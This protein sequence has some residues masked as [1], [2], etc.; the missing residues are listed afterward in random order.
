MKSDK[1]VMIVCLVVI[2][3]FVFFL[4]SINES[5]R[6]S[7]AN[8]EVKDEKTPVTYTCIRNYTNDYNATIKQTAIYTMDGNKI[9]SANFKR[10]Y[11]F[12]NIANYNS[13]KSTISSDKQNGITAT[14]NYDEAGLTINEDK[15]MDLTVMK[16]IDLGNSFPRFYDPDLKNYTAG[17]ECSAIY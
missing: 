5:T 14:Y 3:A 10:T 1:I 4:P 6:N 13:F 7:A 17:Q 9:T 2:G 8:N 15:M 16:L 12:V 11:T